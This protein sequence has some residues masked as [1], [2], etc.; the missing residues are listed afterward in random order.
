MIECWEKMIQRAGELAAKSE[1]TRELLIFYHALLESQKEVYDFLRSRREWLPTGSLAA[2]LPVLRDR[3]HVIF[4]TVELNGPS[5]LAREAKD[6]LSSDREVID[7]M[8]MTV[9]VRRNTASRSS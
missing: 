3:L 9:E 1:A 2:D 7:E 6:V 5:S 8:L 4:R